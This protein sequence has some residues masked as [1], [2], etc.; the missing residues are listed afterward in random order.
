MSDETLFCPQCGTALAEGARTCANDHGI[1]GGVYGVTREDLEA[2][3]RAK[4][5][6]LGVEVNHA[7]IIDGYLGSG[8]FGA[9]YRAVQK[10]LERHV[11]LKLLVLE[12]GTEETVIERFKREARTAAQILDPNVVTLFDYGEAALGD[13][14][15]DR[16]LYM[17]M[18]LIDGPTLRRVIKR[19]KGLG[20][21]ASLKVGVAIL[22]GLAAAHQM[23]VVHRDLKPS[24]VLIDE[25]KGREWHARLFDFG[26]A[27]LQGAGN[28]TQLT[29]EGGVLG[30]PK[31]MAPEQWRALPT[32][33]ATDIY[34]FGCILAEMLTG[35]PPVP[36]MEL[37][38]MARAHCR[39][40]RPHVTMTSK[41]ESVPVALTNFIK[42]CTGVDPSRRY[43][44]A[45]EALEVLEAVSRDR[46]AAHVPQV[47]PQSTWPRDDSGSDIGPMMGAEPAGTPPA[48]AMASSDNMVAL[49]PAAT[50][51][52]T[53]V[54]APSPNPSGEWS[55]DASQ[56]TGSISAS[57]SREA[58]WDTGGPPPPAPRRAWAIGALLGAVAAILLVIMFRSETSPG[59]VGATAPAPRTMVPAQPALPPMEDTSPDDSK[60]AAHDGLSG[61]NPEHNTAE[62]NTAEHKTAELEEAPVNE[63]RLDAPTADP[64]TPSETAALMAEPMKAPTLQKP[65]PHEPVPQMAGTEPPS[66]AATE[67][68]VKADV[69]AQ[70]P[71]KPRAQ[72]PRRVRKRRAAPKPAPEPVA[73][74][75]VVVKQAPA[76]AVAS[77][78][79]PAQVIPKQVAP[80]PTT[81]PAALAL[82]DKARDAEHRGAPRSAERLYRKALDG[83]LQ[84]SEARSARASIKRLQQTIA[85]DQNEF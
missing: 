77:A 22:R 17:A 70:V 1:T 38:E 3:P 36:K 51:V 58:S 50:P 60:L 21:E 8:G 53:G 33:P 55:P 40:P 5:H 16:V 23:G 59:V 14:E 75:E 9:V 13:H 47:A 71:P 15:S 72:K 46:D 30:T 76:T 2:T 62:H 63:M 56:E 31:Y 74:E 32:T 28:H 41:G 10:T 12:A 65:L 78:I 35:Q 64:D 25:S 24:N 39:G 57:V 54:L 18:E 43:A 27:S 68:S 34:A 85:L 6:L 37:A 26:I 19:S 81:P 79:A 45:Q 48:A 20:L 7:Y 84:G 49:A 4:R 80:Q 83:G 52:P 11:A 44:V 67:P 66:E 69:V 42:R 82:Y 73:V 29:N 61:S